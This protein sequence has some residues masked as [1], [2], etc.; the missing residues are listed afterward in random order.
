MKG[1]VILDLSND[2]LQMLI[3][4]LDLVG[5]EATRVPGMKTELG[6][7]KEKLRAKLREEMKRLAGETVET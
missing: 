1:E 7:R 4:S 3:E 2:E 5:W 6:R